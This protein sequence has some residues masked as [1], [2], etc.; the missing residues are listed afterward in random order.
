M[1]GPDVGE[2]LAAL[3][4]E[5]G[6]DVVDRS[7]FVPLPQR[8]EALRAWTSSSSGGSSSESSSEAQGSSS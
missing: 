3:A 8:M 1:A 7:S 4:L 2:L 5:G 6:A